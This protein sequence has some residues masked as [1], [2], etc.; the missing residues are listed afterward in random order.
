MREEK[1]TLVRFGTFQIRK[2]KA[3]KGVNPQTREAINISA[4][5]VPRFRPRK[6]L[7]EAVS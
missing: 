5:K 2:R 6:G 1:V 3:R 4:K 7:R